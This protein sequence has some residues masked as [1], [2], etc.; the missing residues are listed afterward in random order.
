MHRKCVAIGLIFMLT[1]PVFA[2][3]VQEIDGREFHYVTFISRAESEGST[4]GDAIVVIGKGRSADKMT[5]EAAYGMVESGGDVQMDAL[6][7]RRV[8]R[9]REHRGRP[10]TQ[11]LIV[12]VT[13]EQ[14]D[15][16][17]DLINEWSAKTEF[18][19]PT[20]I[21]STNFAVEVI[22]AVG[23]DMPYRT[24]LGV[25]NPITFYQDL[26]LLNR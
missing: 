23:L 25:Q 22:K 15:R 10:E 16:V 20:I 8:Q 14:Y 18:D 21:S 12:K 3:K 19:V 24:G 11:T 13:Q 1:A 9:I 4:S 6:S 2:E 7:E 26:A 5:Y 17:A